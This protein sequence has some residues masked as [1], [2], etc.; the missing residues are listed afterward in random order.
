MALGEGVGRASECIAGHSERAHVYALWEINPLKVLIGTPN[1]A[2]EFARTRTGIEPEERQAE[3]LRSE[4]KRGML[5]IDE[6]SRVEDAM[7][8]ALRPM[9]AVG[10]GDL[11]LM[12]T[13]LWKRGFFC[14]R[15]S[16]EF[17]E[18]ERGAQKGNFET[19]YMCKFIEDGHSV[20]NRDLVMKALGPDGGAVG[21]SGVWELAVGGD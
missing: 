16:R 18:E 2:A 14:P 17:L 12:S 19:E 21:V 9:L 10:S 11:W 20:F 1:K 4:T 8:K 13:P 3:V 15:I 5:L 6:A 7:Y